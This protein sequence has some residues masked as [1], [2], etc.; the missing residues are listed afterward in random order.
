MSNERGGQ[1]ALLQFSIQNTRSCSI[2]K[3]KNA[4]LVIHSQSLRRKISVLQKG[5]KQ[6]GIQE[7]HLEKSCGDL[8]K[9]AFPIHQIG[10]EKHEFTKI[11]LIKRC[12]NRNISRYLIELFLSHFS[13]L[14]MSFSKSVIACEET[15]STIMK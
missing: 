5:E 11:A 6:T 10:K 14:Y 3:V 12:G 9:L 15:H 8:D 2:Y 4:K 1:D 7:K 13:C